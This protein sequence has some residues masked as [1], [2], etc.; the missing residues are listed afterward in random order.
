[1]GMRLL[2]EATK[3]H[4]YKHIGEMPKKQRD[5]ARLSVLKYGR[6]YTEGGEDALAA[7]AMSYIVT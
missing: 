1:M 4:K 2:C 3:A 6:A 7:F 5:S